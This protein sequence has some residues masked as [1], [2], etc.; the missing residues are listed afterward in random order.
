M[1]FYRINPISLPEI[2]FANCT[3]NTV[4]EKSRNIVDH[5][6]GTIE[7]AYYRDITDG[8]IILETEYGSYT[9]PMDV[10]VMLMPDCRYDIRPSARCEKMTI[11]C[12]G[13]RC[14]QLT[15][16]R[17]KEEDPF[18]IWKIMQENPD[19]LILP[20]FFLEPSLQTPGSEETIRLLQAKI[21][22]I[23]NSYKDKSARGRFTCISQWCDL[24]GE[25]DGSFRA[26]IAEQV[27]ADT[28][29]E[30]QKAN[31]AYYYVYKAK[32]YIILHVGERID[33]AEVSAYVG[34]SHAYFV[35]L[36]KKEMGISLNDYIYRMRLYSLCERLDSQ[37]DV[38]GKA[39][40]AECGFQDY[41]HVQRLFQKYIG[42]SIQEYRKQSKGLTLYHT[43]PWQFKNLDEDLLKKDNL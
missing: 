13:V 21:R 1:V 38:S 33:P 31:S 24:C 12:V 25:M 36:F 39:L 27:G 14:A 5:R 10:I 29:N 26:V 40:A 34:V 42:M 4:D 15:Y 3:V 8:H 35:K 30:P 11:A 9:I 28:G 2:L 20:Q 7:L 16:A 18:A 17:M 6:E 32:K 41:R 23:I 37:A 19:S 43:N 22:F